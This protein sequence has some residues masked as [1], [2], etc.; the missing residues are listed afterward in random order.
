MPAISF[1]A[2]FSLFPDN[3]QMGQNFSLS[4]YIFNDL[5][6]SGSLFVNDTATERG[7]QFTNDGLSIML[8]AS[9]NTIDLRL[10]AFA[11]PIRI[12][13]IDSLGTTIHS[14]NLSILN[15]YVDIR[16][17]SLQQISTLKFSDGGNEA[18]LVKINTAFCVS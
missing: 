7:L 5:S 1:T 14:Q 16:I 6:N 13:A 12:D 10:G 15:R 9:N 4:G 8:P 3:T 17:S 18:I 2:E 11:G